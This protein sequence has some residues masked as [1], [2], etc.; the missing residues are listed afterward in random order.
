MLSP[1]SPGAASEASFASQASSE[2]G[3]PGYGSPGGPGSPD[4]DGSGRL[5]TFLRRVTSRV[6]APPF[7]AEA[8]SGESKEWSRGCVG[9]GKEGKG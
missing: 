5:S 6:L 3:S 1:L 4:L 8:W 9:A 2:A 7:A